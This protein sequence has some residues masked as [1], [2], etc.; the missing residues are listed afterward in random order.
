MTV[1]LADSRKLHAPLLVAADGRTSA[2]REAAGDSGSRAGSTTISAIVSVLPPRTARTTM[3]LICNS[4]PSGPFALL[5]MTDDAGR[6]TARRSCGRFPN[7]DA[8]GWLALNDKDFAVGRS[9][10]GRLSRQGRAARAALVLPARLPSRCPDRRAAPRA[11][12]R[13]RPRHPPDRRPGVRTPALL[14]TS[15]HWRRWWSRAPGSGS[16]SATSNCST[17]TSAGV[18]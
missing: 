11:G 14:V 9:G 10:D 7:E 13:F 3:S 1:S 15:P 5:P 12:R 8:T 17:A 16:I 6:S 2:T 18:L 4:D